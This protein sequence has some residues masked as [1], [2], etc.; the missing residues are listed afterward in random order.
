MIFLV[1]VGVGT[2]VGVGV[3]VVLVVVFVGVGVVDGA[4]VG[5]ENGRKGITGVGVG[6]DVSASWATELSCAIMPTL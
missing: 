6:V 2:G 4:V 3:V 1:V 5:I